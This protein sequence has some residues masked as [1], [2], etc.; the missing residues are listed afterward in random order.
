[1]AREFHPARALFWCIGA[2]FVFLGLFLFVDRHFIHILK[3]PSE[4]HQEAVDAGKAEYYLD[5]HHERQ[6]RWK[7]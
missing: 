5:E 2:Y 7:P 3:L 6:W 4:W 1:M